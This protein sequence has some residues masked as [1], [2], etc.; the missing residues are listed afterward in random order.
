VR[1]AARLVAF[2][3]LSL[4]LY[5]CLS[6]AARHAAAARWLVCAGGDGNDT[7]HAGGGI[8][9]Y[10]NGGDGDDALYAGEGAFHM[11]FYGARLPPSARPRRAPA[12]APSCAARATLVPQRIDA[13]ACRASR[14]QATTARTLSTVP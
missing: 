9:M 11:T 2:A 1:P 10:F 7:M 5:L 4:S 12:A 8:D 13:D 3:P 6:P 14:A